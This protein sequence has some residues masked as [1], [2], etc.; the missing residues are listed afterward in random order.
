MAARDSWQVI[1]GPPGT[2]KT[3]KLLDIV[4]DVLSRSTDPRNICFVAFTRK[5]ANEAKFRAMEKFG[6][7]LDD[8]P[9]F[10]TL[11]SLAYRQ[12]GIE[13]RQVLGSYDW[14][15]MAEM[16]GLYITIKGIQEDGT[17]VG[18][19]KG[20]RLFFMEAMSRAKMLDLKDYWQECDDDDIF[21][22][23]LEQVHN[24]I[25]EY[26]KVYGK[27]DFSDMLEEFCSRKPL[28]PLNVL[29]VDEAQ[30]LSPLQWKM[31]YAL[32]EEASE[33]Y[34]AGDDDQAI[35]TWA[36]ADVE[37]FINL[38]GT[39]KVLTKSYRCPKAVHAVAE[40]ITD[41][42][43]LRIE[44][45]YLPA[46]NE[47][48]VDVVTDLNHI[49]M[50]EGTWYLLGRNVYIVQQ[51]SDFCMES[52]YLFQSITSKAISPE[53]IAAIATWEKLRQGRM[54][55]LSSVLPVY[56]LMKAK[57]GWT[58]GS[59]K[60]LERMETDAPVSLENLQQHYGLLTTAIWHEALVRIPKQ[61]CLYIL[62]ALKRG[63]KLLQKPR[64]QCNTIH[65]VKGGEADNV[66]LV[67]DMATRTYNEYKNNPD[68][69]HRVWYVGATRA[70]KNLF[71]VQPETSQY[72]EEIV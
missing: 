35:F 57:E 46:D 67:T 19:T 1:L 28:P 56:D 31:V 64:I 13:K 33:V 34:I 43:D 45:R 30:D 42:M 50:D 48:K 55:P 17:L 60:R 29:I 47:G 16:L 39:K 11:H 72:Y 63:E 51:L 27:I 10:R 15:K 41:Q 37:Q 40:S 52:G 38:P 62:A 8:L 69:E 49:N 26:K 65:G 20:D 70:R 14:C 18:L 53:M 58:W 4:D 2:G 68:P 36:G 54:V 44:K 22:D 71:I 32:A 12:L 25:K 7:T 23:E 66:V 24:T 3:T 61:T 59:K 21:F 6:L 5:A 9:L